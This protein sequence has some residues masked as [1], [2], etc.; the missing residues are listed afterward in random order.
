M[1]PDS[2][3]IVIGTFRM[4]P[5]GYPILIDMGMMLTTKNWIPF[6]HLREVELI[7]AMTAAN[8]AFIKSLR[9][10]LPRNAPIAS[11]LATGTTPPTA[12]FMSPPDGDEDTDASLELASNEGEYPAW[13]W[14]V[15]QDMPTLP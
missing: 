15:D 9:F 12:M 4:A 1:V 3:I 14:K 11:M 8:R 2:H 10:N 13:L 5:A 6:E 7:D